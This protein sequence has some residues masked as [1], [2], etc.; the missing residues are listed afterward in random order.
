M[1]ANNFGFDSGE[2]EMLTEAV[3]LSRHVEGMA[4]E[5]GLREGYGTAVII[6]AVAE[7]CPSKV[8]I[9]VDPYGSILYE[10]REGQICRLDYD[11]NMMVRCIPN[12]YQFAFEHCVTWK[13]INLTDT[14]FFELYKNG[15]PVYD[16]ERVVHQKYSMVHFDGPHSVNDILHEILWFNDRMYSGSTIVIDDITPD[17]FDIVPINELLTSLGWSILKQGLKKGLYQ[18]N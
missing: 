12:M 14:D 11:D 1:T 13:F 16:L 5:I 10:G 3:E 17:F 9:S 15:V 7:N 18:K 4:C 6:E 2:Y 8:V